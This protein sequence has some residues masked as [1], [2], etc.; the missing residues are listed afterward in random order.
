MSGTTDYA[1]A[2]ARLE[3]WVA[4]SGDRRATL[5]HYDGVSG[6]SLERDGWRTFYGSAV[7][8]AEAITRALSRSDTAAREEAAYV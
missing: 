3:A 8:L 6:C 7:T 5:H 4:E 1:A 2:L